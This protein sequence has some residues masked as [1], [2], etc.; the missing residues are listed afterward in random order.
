MT[1]QYAD[2]LDRQILRGQFTEQKEF[3][4]DF[5]ENVFLSKKKNRSL[6]TQYL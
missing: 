3:K 5:A 2:S 1:L 4:D 6:L